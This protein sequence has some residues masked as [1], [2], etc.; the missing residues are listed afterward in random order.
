AVAAARQR[1]NGLFGEGRLAEAEAA[2]SAAMA[3]APC[4]DAVLHC[5]RSVA[6]LKLGDAG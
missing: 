6:R 2:Y 3:E 1:A 4:A 5:N